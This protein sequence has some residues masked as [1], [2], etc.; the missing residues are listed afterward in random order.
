[1]AGGQPQDAV[2]ARG[3]TPAVITL[4]NGAFGANKYTIRYKNKSGQDAEKLVKCTLDSSVLFATLRG[5]FSAF[6]LFLD[7]FTGA[8]FKLPDVATLEEIAYHP[9]ID[10]A[11]ASI[12]DIQPELRRCLI[13]V[14]RADITVTTE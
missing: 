10:I 13:P 12:H 8:L 6:G 11:I 4:P 2:V 7:P 5:V 14:G 1:M 3:V 9:G